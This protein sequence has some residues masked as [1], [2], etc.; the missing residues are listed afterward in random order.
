MFV[1]AERL[2]EILTIHPAATLEPPIA[3]PRSRTRQPTSSS[4]PKGTTLSEESRGFTGTRGDAIVEI[5]RGRMAMAGPTTASALARSLSIGEADVSA[6][7]VTLESE[8][9]ILRGSFTGATAR[10]WCDRHLLARIHRYTINRLRA[11]I[12]PVA[13]SDFMRFLFAWQHVDR[14]TQV[15]GVDG[16]RTV[17]GGL[18]GFAL[19]ASAWEPAVLP[20]RMDRYDPSM[21]DMLCLTG[22]VGW[23]RL[24]VPPR[25]DP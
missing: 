17:V 7:L 20:V 2:R 5:L 15:A 10:E 25:A 13:P 16:L 12:E 14:A 23:A 6:A 21:L 18:D 24:S 4:T 3:P 11:E 19:A 1:A 22:E 9:V 8:G